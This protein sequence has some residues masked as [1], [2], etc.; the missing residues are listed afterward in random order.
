MQSSTSLSTRRG[1][2]VFKLLV[3]LAVSFGVLTAAWIFF[4]P[5]VLASTLTKRTGFE[6]KVERLV[7][8]PFSSNVDIDGLV[9][10]NPPAFPHSDYVQVRNFQAQAPLSSL[11]GE[12]PEFDYVRV[13]VAHMSFVRNADGT[14]NAT[15]F[16]DRLFPL[17][18]PLTEKEEKERKS[19]ASAAGGKASPKI[20]REPALPRPRMAFLIHRLELKIDQVTVADYLGNNPTKRDFTLGVNQTFL[21]VTDAKQLFTPAMLRAIAPAATT[22]AALVPGDLGKVLAAAAGGGSPRDPSKKPADVV[23][24][25]VDTLE[26][27]RKP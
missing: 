11:F 9:V 17:E 14:L 13:D 24:S 8:N 22:I 23:K 7:I 4:L 26:E 15:L 1:G 21:E 27:S 12:R 18:K 25:L 10:L 19:K 20:V 6:V 5:L 2:A 3:F 16:Y